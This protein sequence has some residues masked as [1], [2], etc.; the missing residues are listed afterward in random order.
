MFPYN[1]FEWVFQ[2]QLEEE[3][4]VALE[5]AT[6]FEARIGRLTAEMED[7]QEACNGLLNTNR[8]LTDEN[9]VCQNISGLGR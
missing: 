7:L 8:K 3:K 4:N 1:S 9:K 5:R 2:S 6:H